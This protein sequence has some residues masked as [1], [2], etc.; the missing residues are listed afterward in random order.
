MASAVTGLFLSFP[1]LGN[2]LFVTG[3]FG[4]TVSLVIL[5]VGTQQTLQNSA[6]FHAIS[7]ATG[8][9]NGLFC[10]SVE[11][12]DV[13]GGGQGARGWSEILKLS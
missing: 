8:H 3:L 11:A 2:V 13:H 1:R 6:L 12:G 10:V 4:R 7:M 5:L 9:K